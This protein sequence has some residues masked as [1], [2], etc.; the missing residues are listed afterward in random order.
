MIFGFDSVGLVIPYTAQAICKDYA[1]AGATCFPSSEIQSSVDHYRPPHGVLEGQALSSS[2]PMDEG[3]STLCPLFEVARDSLETQRGC[4]EPRDYLHLSLEPIKKPTTTPT[5]RSTT[6]PKQPTGRRTGRY[7][8]E[9]CGDSFAQPQ[10]ATR[11]HREKHEPETCRYCHTFKWGRLYLYRR[12]V[13]IEH[14]EV[15][16]EAATIDATMNPRI[17]TISTGTIQSQA[18]HRRFGADEQPVQPEPSPASSPLN[19]HRH[20]K[21]FD[22]VGKSFRAGS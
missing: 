2:A 7:S 19:P 8:C 6:S 9:I 16:L 12:H 17:G 18:P 4:E 20:A 22:V 13:K 10:G 14:P 15:D 21:S 5:S 11:H 1:S 3:S